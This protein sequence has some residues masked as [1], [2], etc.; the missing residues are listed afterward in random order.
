MEAALARRTGH[1][2]LFEMPF[3]SLH[4]PPGETPQCSTPHTRLTPLTFSMMSNSPTPETFGIWIHASIL[5]TPP[6]GALKFRAFVSMRADVQLPA[7]S[8]RGVMRRF[9]PRSSD[10]VA[11]VPVCAAISPVPQFAGPPG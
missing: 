1:G 10:T 9:P 2:R 4:G 7:P 8:R 11:G 6:A 5:S 3:F